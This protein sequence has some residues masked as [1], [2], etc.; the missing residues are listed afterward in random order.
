MHLLP[1]SKLGPLTAI[2]VFRKDHLRDWHDLSASDLNRTPKDFG[3]VHTVRNAM[4]YSK[5]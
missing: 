1:A 3:I 5:L 2:L 4:A